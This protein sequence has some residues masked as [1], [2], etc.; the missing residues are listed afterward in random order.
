MRD[1]RL[2]FLLFLL[3]CAAFAGECSAL[4]CRHD[5]NV[6]LRPEAH[7]ILV[8]D[9]LRL[10]SVEIDSIDLIIAEKAR[11]EELR[12]DGAPAEY[13]FESGRITVPLPPGATPRKVELLLSYEAVFDDSVPQEVANFDNPGFGVTGIVSGKGVFLPPDSGWYARLPDAKVEFD[14]RVVAPKGI[15]AVTAGELIGHTDEEDR[16]VSSWK[17][18]AIGQGPA[19]SAGRYVVHSNT[20]GRIPVMTYLLPD[21][22]SLSETYLNASLEHLAF[23]EKL[24]GPYPFPK[25]AVVENFFPT[26][27]G[28]PSYTLMGGTVLRLPFI[29]QTSLRHEIAHSW[30]GNGVLVDY[31][32]GNWC[33]G[34]ATYVA[35]YLAREHV[36]AEE[37][38]LYRMQILQDYATLAAS[39]ADFPL[40]KFTGRTSPSTRAVGYGKAAFL[41]HMIR[42]R[43]GDAPFWESLRQVFRE[44]LFAK[45]S[46]IDFRDAFVKTG[47]W[48]AQEAQ[49][50]FEQWIS[51]PG[52]PSLKLQQVRSSKRGA[53]RRVSGAI[54]QARP[55]FDFR[56][57]LALTDSEDNTTGAEAHPTGGVTR[58]AI[59]T[60]KAPKKLVA[61]PGVNVFRLLS[62]REI[63]ATVNSLK[64][65]GNLAAITADGI[66]REM[67]PAFSTLLE[68]LGRRGARMLSEKEADLRKIKSADLLF[69]GLPRSKA[70][71]SLL[72]LSARTYDLSVFSEADCLFL[73]FADPRRTGRLTALLLPVPGAQRASVSA[74]AHKITHYGKYSYLAFSDG[75]VGTKG[76]WETKASPLIF[77]FSR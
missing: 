37:G 17:T 73:V 11:M 61:D 49:A 63:P 15:Y 42:Q 59:Q 9:T 5:L 71:S 13:S 39:G 56:I 23:Y 14:I 69:F 50:F 40:N 30:W 18:G 60:S 31:D 51:R 27:Y 6:E 46:W 66:D 10:E 65:S 57:N 24:H 16:T 20:A 4:T 52:A 75:T 53:N 72:E 47:G 58:F 76:V 25:F 68:G 28:F 26:G 35:D 44:R 48:D 8:K 64:A 54:V 38:R 70:L 21:S 1:F 77:E 34:L 36:S 43:I 3:C 7:S 22:D 19:L 12:V 41:F 29:P 2:F 55:F 62:P 74:A 33:E 32:S 45:A 67:L